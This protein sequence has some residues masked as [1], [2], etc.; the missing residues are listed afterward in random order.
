MYIFAKVISDTRKANS[1]IQD[2]NTVHAIHFLLTI[3]ATT[4]MLRNLCTYFRY[5]IFCNFYFVKHDF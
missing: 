4:P 2:L 5:I 1:L 3:T